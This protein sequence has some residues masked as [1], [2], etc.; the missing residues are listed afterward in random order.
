MVA[1]KK[2]KINLKDGKTLV[3]DA[4]VSVKVDRSKL[5]KEERVR[6]WQDG[7][8]DGVANRPGR[9]WTLD[10]FQYPFQQD[11]DDGYVQGKENGIEA[12]VLI[13][14]RIFEENK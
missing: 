2:L 13:R 10:L 7:F 1:R 4:P 6:W 5:D 11:Y 12:E 9:I 3:S 14:R 8:C